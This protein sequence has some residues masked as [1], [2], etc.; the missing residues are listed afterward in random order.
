MPDCD[1]GE[2]DAE[3]ER[4][5]Q[6]GGEHD[7]DDEPDHPDREQRHVEEPL[8]V[9]L[10]LG[11]AG[12]V[13]RCRCGA[14]REQEDAVDERPDDRG[15]RVGEEDDRGRLD[16]D[17]DD[18]RRAPLRTGAA[19]CERAGASAA[20]TTIAPAM[21]VAL[22][23]I[24]FI[25]RCSRRTA[26]MIPIA[27]PAKTFQL[28]LAQPIVR[29]RVFNRSEAIP[30]ATFSRITAIGSDSRSSSGTKPRMTVAAVSSTQMPISTAVAPP[31]R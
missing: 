19:R 23:M 17:R 11:G 15:A 14:V 1:Q 4:A 8:V 26:G 7:A 6:P 5:E 2:D 20:T 31:K 27:A 22:A 21:N 16:R 10:D 12:A 25:P 28:R 3:A 9:V 24:S 18:E 29:S 30:T 13:E